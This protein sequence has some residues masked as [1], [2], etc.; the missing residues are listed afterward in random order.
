VIEIQEQDGSRWMAVTEL[1]TQWQR[2]SLD[3]HDFQYWS[4]SSTRGARGGRGDRLQ[5]EQARRVNFQLAQ[6]HAPT[7]PQGEH[8]FWI[9]DIGTCVNP[10]RDLPLTEALPDRSLETIFP[11][12]KVYP[13]DEAVDHPASRRS[14]DDHGN[15]SRCSGMAV[16]GCSARSRG[17]WDGGW[18]VAS[19]GVIFRCWMRGMP[20]HSIGQPGVARS[21]TRGPASR[22]RV[23]RIGSCTTLPC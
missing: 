1:T 6:S 2:I 11:R 16:G 14:D 9:T 21:P 8:R 20:G 23:G 18:T 13:L 5:P 15:R 4:D 17:R 12:Y 3:P 7:L 22:E 10:V 19:L